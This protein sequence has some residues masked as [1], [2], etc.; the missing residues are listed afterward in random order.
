MTQLTREE[1]LTLL[2]EWGW[3]VHGANPLFQYWTKDGLGGAQVIGL[4]LQEDFV[5][6]DRRLAEAQHQLAQVEAERLFEI[7]LNAIGRPNLDDDERLQAG[8]LDCRWMETWLWLPDAVID[9]R[10]A[11]DGWGWEPDPHWEQIKFIGH[12]RKGGVLVRTNGRW[13]ESDEP[14][15]SQRGD[16]QFKRHDLVKL[17]ALVAPPIPQERS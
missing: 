12:K 17:S 3:K 2:D 10:E 16:Y 1:L 8:L 14:G 13:P 15:A 11:Q 9:G 6:Y 7:S 5:D 4:P